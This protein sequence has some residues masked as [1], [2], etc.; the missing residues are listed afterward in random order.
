MARQSRPPVRDERGGSGSIATV[1]LVPAF[2][3]LVFLII[4]AGLFWHGQG[5]AHAA[6]AAG[7]EA[8]RVLN[9]P[10]GAAEQ[11]ARQ[12]AAQG[13]LSEL[14]VAVSQSNQAVTVTVTGNVPRLVAV[15]TF[16]QIS[17]VA[18]MPREQVTSP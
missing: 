1:L 7:A 9:A 8:A 18:T 15:G 2:M 6:A 4:Q 11:A 14:S 17:Q 13:G 12:I 10:A 5:T 3:G 16:G